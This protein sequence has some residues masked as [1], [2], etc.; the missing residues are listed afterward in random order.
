MRNN[1]KKIAAAALMLA[2]TS[3]F[4]LPEDREQPIHISADSASIDDKT[5][6]TSYKGSVNI[7]QGSLEIDAAKVEMH[8]GSEGVEKIIAT[9]RKN[10]QARFRQQ[11]AK[12]EPYTD[13]EGNRLVYLVDKQTITVTGNAFV[14]QGSDKFSG[15]KIVYDIDKSI[16]NAFGGKKGKGRVQMVIQPKAKPA[17]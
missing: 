13:A 16:V 12:S 3:V 17:Q 7:R 2:C 5:G 1:L 9:G 10:K 6:I 4:A 8:R 14:Q 15:E 11:S